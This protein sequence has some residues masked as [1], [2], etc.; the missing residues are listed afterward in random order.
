[1]YKLIAFDCDGTL[2]NDDKK[3]DSK[4]IES[5]KL[6]KE[7]G[8]K[9]VLA[10]S[11]PFYRVL[12][13]LKELN[14]IDDTSYTISFNGG[15]VINNTGNNPLCDER[16]ST[17]IVK[18]ILSYSQ[19]YDLYTFVYEKEKVLANKYCEP[20]VKQNPDTKFEVQDLLKLDLENLNIYK[21]IIH[22]NYT[23]VKEARKNLEKSLTSLCV[24]T[25]SNK[26]N[27]EF[28]PLGNSKSNGLKMIGEQLSIK[29]NEM[30][31]F[32]D[33]ENDIDMFNYVGYKVAMGNSIKHLKDISD[34]VTLSNNDFGIAKAI[35][36]MIQDG[37]IK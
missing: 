8:I 23:K 29:S 28:I 31:A 21:I 30:I 10:T 22:G 2:L 11:R 3:I 6:L 9:V 25:S 14:L 5:I 1:M 24:V 13:Y 4:T 27:I 20:Y 34:K 7:Y 18:R 19:N 32:G 33:N 16:L 35:E 26:N 17:D 36:E 12:P 37:I 15:L